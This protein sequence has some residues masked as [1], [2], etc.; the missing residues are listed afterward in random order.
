M[1][2]ETT[3]NGFKIDETVIITATKQP[4]KIVSF[5]GGRWKVKLDSGV[6]VLKEGNEIQRRQVLLG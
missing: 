5:E 4:G 6:T 3:N 1:L 2:K